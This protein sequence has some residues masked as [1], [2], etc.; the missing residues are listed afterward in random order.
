MVRVLRQ[1]AMTSALAGAAWGCSGA[2]HPLACH[3][4]SDC[5]S[6]VCRADGI[7]GSLVDAGR[8]PDAG[9]NV[10]AG[11]TNAN[12]DAGPGDADAGNSL[13]AGPGPLCADSADGSISRDQFPV[14]PG[15]HATYRVAQNAMV[16]TVGTTLPD[17]GSLWDF[18]GALAGDGDVVIGTSALDGGWYAG[19]YPSATYVAPLSPSSNLLGVFEATAANLLLLGV[20]SPDPGASQ[21]ELTYSPPALVLQFPIVPGAKWQSTSNITG[22]LD[23]I[24]IVGLYTETY[25][26]TVDATGDVLT[27]FANFAAQRIQTVLTRTVG[28]LIS[29]STTYVYATA[30]FG[31]VATVV[32]QADLGT[33]NFTN[34]SVV[35]RLGQ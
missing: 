20:V 33:T 12:L 15:V 14:A 9:S 34:A 6:N 26:S 30:C 5:A 17:G 7:C 29:G 1:L 23:G 19:Q 28:A 24:E 25:A 27:P 16:S 22:P 21:T 8:T 32:S 10:D 4:A 31:G 3:V 11:S 13:D 2:N 35:E 18:T